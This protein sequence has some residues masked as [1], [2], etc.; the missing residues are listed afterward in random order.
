MVDTVVAAVA[1]QDAV[2][3]GATHIWVIMPPTI[4]AYAV[5]LETMCLTMD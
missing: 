5:L 4:K 1:V 2:M 3:E